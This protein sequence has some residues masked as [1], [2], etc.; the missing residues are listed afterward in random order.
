MLSSCRRI[1]IPISHRGAH[2]AKGRTSWS[3]KPELSDYRSFA[4]FFMHYLSYLQPDPPPDA[5]FVP[6]QLP[7]LAPVAAN[8]Q[9][10][11]QA[12]IV[13][14]AGYSYGSTILRHLPPVPSI[15]QPFAAPPTGSAAH[16]ALLCAHKLAAQANLEFLN[17]ARDRARRSRRA[18]DHKLSVK[19]GGEETT[20]GKRRSS[21]E[22]RRSLDGGKSLYIGGRL[23]SLSHG[24]RRPK[25]PLPQPPAE[26]EK[27]PAIQVP[28]VRYLLVSPLTPPTSTLATLGLARGFW[29]RPG[30][31]DATL[32]KHETLAVYGDQDMFASA[33]K[34][35]EWVVRME[36]E[37]RGGFCGVEVTDA[38]HFWHEQGVE[39]QLR[40]TLQLWEKRVRD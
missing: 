16:E 14:L 21:R 40:E 12:P 31:E 22:I 4:G 39:R 7:V 24:H 25:D 17:L 23:R 2:G 38:G 10:D 33:K 36:K 26:L 3:G 20:P 1:R 5:A 30:H 11:E 8:Q 6:E 29:G 35:R 9:L 28:E 37:N 34:M 18:H 19:M 15:L 27:R 32:T 13:V